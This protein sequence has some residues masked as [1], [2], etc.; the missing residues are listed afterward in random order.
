YAEDSHD[1]VKVVPIK[2]DADS[3]PVV[4]SIE[5]VLTGHYAIARPLHLYTPNEAE[6]LAKEF[7]DYCASDVGQKIVVETGYIPLKRIAE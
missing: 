4:P 7:L 6:G 3:D 2:Q 1:K 5:T